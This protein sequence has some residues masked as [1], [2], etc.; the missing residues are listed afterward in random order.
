MVAV[1]SLGIRPGGVAKAGL[2]VPAEPDRQVVAVDAQFAVRRVEAGSPPSLGVRLAPAPTATGDPLRG[3]EAWYAVTDT[4]VILGARSTVVSSHLLGHLDDGVL[5]PLRLRMTAAE[6]SGTPESTAGTVSAVATLACWPAKRR[7]ALGRAII[8]AAGE[9]LT[10]LAVDGSEST[11]RAL[12]W[13]VKL[14][15]DFPADPLV[16]APLL[17]HLRR[18]EAGTTYLVPPE[19]L[20]GHLSGIAVGVASAG[21]TR[22]CGGLDPAAVDGPTFVAAVGNRDGAVTEPAGT[23]LDEAVRYAVRLGRDVS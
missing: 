10:R 15:E 17:L 6:T 19:T 8:V 9:A 3:H 13:V 20:F 2:R 12:R 22:I 23:A 1:E 7:V 21:S 14:A 18:F 11:A 5:N 16:L 4:L